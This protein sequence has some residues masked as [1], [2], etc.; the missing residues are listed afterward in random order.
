LHHRL[1]NSSE[2]EPRLRPSSQRLTFRHTSELVAE[3]LCE[4]ESLATSGKSWE[5]TLPI[6][7]R[8]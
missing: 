7:V 4:R 1:K 2:D 8:A 3:L 5:C 6:D